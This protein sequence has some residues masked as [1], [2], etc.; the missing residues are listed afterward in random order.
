VDRW[1]HLAP[2]YGLQIIGPPMPGTDAAPASAPAGTRG[3]T[4][5]E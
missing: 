5:P 2:G 3:R 1:L 4:G